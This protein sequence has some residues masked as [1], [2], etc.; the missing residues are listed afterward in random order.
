MVPVTPADN[1]NHLNLFSGFM[2]SSP[3]P[4]RN[5]GRTLGAGLFDIVPGQA[6]TDYPDIDT[7]LGTGQ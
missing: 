5:T 1:R 7:L 3:D 4:G 2:I 6:P